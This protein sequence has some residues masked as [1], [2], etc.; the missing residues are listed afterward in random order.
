[1]CSPWIFWS[2]STR[3]LSTPNRI[4]FTDLLMKALW[5]KPL[6]FWALVFLPLMSQIYKN[7]ILRKK[8]IKLEFFT[9]WLYR[10]SFWLRC[11]CSV[12][13]KTM[14]T[15]FKL[16]SLNSH[17]SYQFSSWT[18]QSNIQW[19]LNHLQTLNLKVYP[20]LWAMGI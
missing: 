3:D 18:R 10:R 19:M 4:K 20:L 1:M 6:S 14:Q 12:S 7:N 8:K 11:L 13:A 2:T 16:W 17:T 15:I 9:L 5:L